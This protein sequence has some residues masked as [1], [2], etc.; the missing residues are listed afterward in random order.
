MLLLEAVEPYRVD[1][2]GVRLRLLGERQ[3]VFGVAAREVVCLAGLL[4]PL[5]RVLADRLQHPEAV[6]VADADEALVD[7]GLQRVEVGVADLLGRLERAA[8]AE[9]GEPREET[10]LVFG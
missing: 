6:V 4:E 3:E 10:L 1:F 5:G 9:D 2:A 8:A 7:E